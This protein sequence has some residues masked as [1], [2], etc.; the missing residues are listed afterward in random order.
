MTPIVVPAAPAVIRHRSLTVSDSE[1]V[2]SSNLRIHPLAT[3]LFRGFVAICFIDLRHAARQRGRRA[4]DP[5]RPSGQR[6][7]PQ[8][9]ATPRRFR[10]C[11]RSRSSLE[12]GC[13]STK[14]GHLA[15]RREGSRCACVAWALAQARIPAA[16]RLL[17][18]THSDRRN[19]DAR[20]ELGR[21]AG[22]S[23]PQTCPSA[24]WQH[25]NARQTVALPSTTSRIRF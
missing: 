6:R 7:C 2:D 11:G 16:T 20:R 13:N 15:S 12:A 23:V 10:T 9:P 18:N 21:G 3:D 17:A 14:A 19:N 4:F 8:L 25:G 5:R 1:P 22:I 24:Q